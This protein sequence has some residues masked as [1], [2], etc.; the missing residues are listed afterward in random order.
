MAETIIRIEGASDEEATEVEE[1]QA[2]EHEAQAVEGEQ[3]RDALSNVTAR[4]DAL[5]VSSREISP[6]LRTVLDEQRALIAELQA[7]NRTQAQQL[8]EIVDKYLL[9]QPLQQ[10][11]D[12]QI[13]TIP[14]AEPEEAQAGQEVIVEAP[15]KRRY[16]A[17]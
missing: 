15:P 17:L 9:T 12:P 1:I 16:R 7:T 8:Q 4:L 13:V 11:P 14:L 5:S 2:S 10:E 6:E 3:W